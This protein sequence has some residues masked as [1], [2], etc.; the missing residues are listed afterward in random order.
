MGNSKEAVK[1]VAAKLVL[2]HIAGEVPVGSRYQTQIDLNGPGAAQSFELLA[3][4]DAE[5]LLIK[6]LEG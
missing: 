4:K 1:Q 2:S 5:E 3:P 6:I